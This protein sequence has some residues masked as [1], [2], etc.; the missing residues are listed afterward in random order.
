MAGLWPGGA[1]DLSGAERGCDRPLQMVTT[2]GQSGCADRSRSTS[3]F[4]TRI[5]SWAVSRVNYKTGDA[6]GGGS[7]LCFT[8]PLLCLSPALPF[9]CNYP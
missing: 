8:F 3:A 6:N 4:S 1:S 7:H 5:R 9:P 2:L